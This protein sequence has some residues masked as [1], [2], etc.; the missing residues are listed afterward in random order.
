MFGGIRSSVW[1][2]RSRCSPVGSEFS[3][4]RGSGARG[5]FPWRRNFTSYTNRMRRKS[6]RWVQAEINGCK[7][8]GRSRPLVARVINGVRIELIERGAGVRFCSCIRASASRRRPG[9]RS[10]GGAGA[11]DRPEPSGFGGSEQPPG[12]TPSTISPISISIFSMS[13]ISRMPSWPRF[14]L[15]AGSR[16]RWR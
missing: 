5:K 9:A 6:S 1:R 11:R 7:Q 12:F 15:A 10:P 2:Y 16:P 14:R 4:C 8:H 3:V 13:S